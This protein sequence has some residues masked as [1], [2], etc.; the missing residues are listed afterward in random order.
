MIFG[1]IP[2]Y[3]CPTNFRQMLGGGTR[4]FLFFIF[5]NLFCAETW[6]THDSQFD[7]LILFE[8]AG[9]LTTNK[10]MKDD[11]VGRSMVS[12]LLT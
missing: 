6:E 10:M 9:E 3:P 1:G 12:F 4:T 11:D 7:K 2:G 5:R 8:M